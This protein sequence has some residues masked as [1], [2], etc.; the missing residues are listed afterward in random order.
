MWR[1]I[2]VWKSL[3]ISYKLWSKLASL[4]KPFDEN[5]ISEGDHCNARYQI[6]LSNNSRKLLIFFGNINLGV[7]TL[8]DN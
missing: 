6:K 1:Y 4:C 2:E 3:K 7:V 5:T 8:I